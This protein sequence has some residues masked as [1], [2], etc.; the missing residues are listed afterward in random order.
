MNIFDFEIIDSLPALYHEGLD[1][2]VISDLHLG[3]EAAV[4]YDGNYVPQFQLEEIKQDVH[5]LKEE[6]GASRILVNGDLKHE[7]K[8]N[9]F[10]E[11]KEIRE[12]FELLDELFEQVIV[13]KGNHDTFIEDFI[14]NAVLKEDLCEKNVLFTHGHKEINPEIEYETLVIGHEHPALELEDE[15]GVTE[16]VDCFLYGKTDEDKEIIVLPAFSKMA[17]GS[18]VNRMPVK[19]LLS[20]VLRNEVAVSNLKA[21]AV[22]K[23]AGLFDFPEIKK[24]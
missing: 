19:D 2:V 21:I 7:F 23:E 18:A 9:R 11:E 20:P 24:I 14:G 3:L 17:G 10:S 12:F 22:D 4:S 16:K 13:I 8:Y 6:T 1:M 5:K 15:I